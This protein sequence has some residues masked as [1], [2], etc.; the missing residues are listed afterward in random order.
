MQN[1]IVNG[2][3]SIGKLKNAKYFKTWIIRILINE[4]NHIYSAQKE[5]NFEE[6]DEEK[7][8]MTSKDYINEAIE[9]I[10]FFE[11]LKKLNYDERI[12]IT[13]FYLEDLSIKDISKI[14]N[15]PKSTVQTKLS[16]S[17]AKLK[18]IL[19]GGDFDNE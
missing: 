17:R 7:I 9:N 3:I 4:C 19:E 1:T 12:V 2:F 15:I 5:N 6:Y 18:K 11:L 13:L 8:T 10:D 14:L 16:R